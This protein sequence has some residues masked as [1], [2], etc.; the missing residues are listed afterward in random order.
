MKKNGISSK[1]QTRIGKSVAIIFVL[2][3][4][5]V[6][7]VTNS[8][9]TEANDTELTLESQSAAYQLSDFFNQ[10]CS[11][12]EGMTTNLQIQKYLDTTMVYADIRANENFE[13]TMNTLKS[14]QALHPDTILASWIADSD[15]SGLVMSDGYIAEEGWQ[16]SS[17]PWYKCTEVKHTI[18]TEP[19]EDVN[20]GKMV[21]TVATPI[22]NSTGKLLGVAG[23]D[24]LLDDIIDIMGDYVI[25]ESG[26]VM[27]L[28]SEGM[29][30]Y[31]PS[32]KYINT[33][34]S[35]MDISKE[36]I[37][38][39]LNK[40]EMFTKYKVD[41]EPKFG[42]VTTI[43][44]TGYVVISCITSSEYYQSIFMI[45]TMLIAIFAIG[46]VVIF[47]SMRKAAV[48]I[49]KPL[50]MLNETA[51]QLAEGNLQVELNVTS[52]DEIGELADSIGKTVTRLKEYINYIDEISDVLGKIA[53]GKLRINLKYS[54]AGE[55]GKVKDALIHIS[56]SMIGVMKNINSTSQQ[57]GAGSDELARAA[58]SLAE[59]AE[60]Q[61]VA[62][63]ELLATAITVAQQVEENKNDA[64]QSAIHTNEVTTMME[65]SQQQMNR[66]REAMN[67]IQEASNKVVGIIKTIED[68]ASQTNLL[69]LNASI[70]AARAGDI[71][72]GFAVVAGEIGNLANESARAVNT[73]R[74]L[75]SVS[76]DEIKKGNALV[77]D[78]VKSL[79]EAVTKIDEVN[80]MIQK[81]A[82]NAVTQMQSMN[83]IKNGV[84]E[85]SHGIQDNSA[86]AEETSATS[87]QLAA[88][89]ITLNELV[90]KFE[91][92]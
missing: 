34:I 48:Q 83:Q 65:E 39:V 51:Q 73:T 23:L 41:G 62:V 58:Q 27:L 3:A 92:N 59:G 13:S 7:L 70:E 19:Y 24:I 80:G 42:Y 12:A 60:S 10:Y 21:L 35:D 30:I 38:A 84:D 72:K 67:N 31:H 50:E 37:D 85:M 76:L 69:S 89:V 20:T 15:V 63:E 2:V 9:I 78:V 71:G 74:D 91:L 22:Y 54:Y 77:D 61:S 44:D 90:G 17:R 79:S 25:G 46:M 14:I 33:Y 56:E 57:V 11:I 68:I 45:G 55:F 1:I 29:Y 32:P 47:I 75:I 66:M 87:E 26:Y 64:K 82:E 36:V 40:Q 6:V 43:G 53:D 88:Q 28:S 86:M 81:T 4:L 5:I 16:V 18:L 49:T 8:S 52:D